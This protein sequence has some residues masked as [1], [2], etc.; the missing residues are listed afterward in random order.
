MLVLN[1]CKEDIKWKEVST[2]SGQRNYA[3]V[4]VEK[5]KEKDKFDNTHSVINGQSKEQ[6]A[7]KSKKEYVGSGKEYVFEKKEFVNQQEAEDLPF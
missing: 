1:I 5:R 4:V 6:R 2:K 7:E 3:T